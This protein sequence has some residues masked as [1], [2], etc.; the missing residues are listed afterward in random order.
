VIFAILAYVSFSSKRLLDG[1][2]VVTITSYHGR[3][4]FDPS[5]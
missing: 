5:L 4:S 2:S 3:T 1:K